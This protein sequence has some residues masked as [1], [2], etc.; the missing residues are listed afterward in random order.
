MTDQYIQRLTPQIRHILETSDLSTVSAKAVRKQLVA[1]GED[2]SAIKASRS[3]IDEVISEIYDSLTAPAPVSPASSDDVPLTTQ[4]KL[5]PPQSSQPEPLRAAKRERK[6]SVS[7]S[8]SAAS[9]D[10]QE[11]TDEQMARRLQSQFDGEGSSSRGARPTRAGA[12][13]KV[14]KKRKKVV[15]KSKANVGSDGEGEGEVKKK[16]RGGEAGNTAFNKELILS[17]A[18]S[19]LV[20]TQRLSRPQVVKHIWDYVKERSLQDQT[21]KRYILCDDKLFKV[22]HTE[23]LH[24]FTMNKILVDHVRNPE[25]VIFKEEREEKPVDL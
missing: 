23:R 3:K 10:E 21:D 16:R 9:E 1:K 5:E 22:F 11:E 14:V 8:A 15:K 2:E 25:D 7:I 12:N 17:D 20:G 18:L 19:D 4:P 13:G 6:P 24:M